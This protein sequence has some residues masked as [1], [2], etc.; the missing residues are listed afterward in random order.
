MVA[1]PVPSGAAQEGA[2]INVES[3]TGSKLASKSQ[4]SQLTRRLGGLGDE[5]SRIRQE[6]DHKVKD[7]LFDCDSLPL[8]VDSI[9]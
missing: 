7:V 2:E 3:S 9:A 6:G 8:R 4:V 5:F 1:V